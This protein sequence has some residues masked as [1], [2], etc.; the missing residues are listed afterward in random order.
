MTLNHLLLAGAVL[1]LVTGAGSA[2]ETQWKPA[3]DDFDSA[4]DRAVREG[5]EPLAGLIARAESATLDREPMW[6]VLGHYKRN[7]F[8]HVESD[9]DGDDF[10]LSA[11][12]RQDPRAELRATLAAFMDTR[13]LPPYGLSAQCRFAARLKWLRERLQIAPAVIPVEEC[14][15][16]DIFMEG[17]KGSRL[18]VVFPSAHPNN[19]SSMYGHTLLRVDADP[20][21]NTSSLLSYSVTYG[22]Q[23]ENV[24]AAA[25]IWKGLVG[26]LYGRFSILPYYL[27]LREYGQLEDR[28]VWEYALNVPPER[29]DM[30]LRHAWELAPTRFNYKFFTENCSYELLS[31]LDAGSPE[32]DLQG[33]FSAWVTP[34]DTLKAMR[35]AGLV[36]SVRYRPAYHAIIR[37]RRSSLTPQEQSIA[38]RIAREQGDPAALTANL[39]PARAA[40]TLDL[41]YDY[42]RYDRIREAHALDARLTPFERRVLLERS[43]LGITGDAVTPQVP[44]TAPDQGHGT[45]RMELGAASV[46]GHASAL[47]GYRGTYHDLLDPS[48]GYLANSQLE[49]VNL[50]LRIGESGDAV[51]LDR[52]TLLSIDSL[53]PRDTFFRNTSWALRTGFDSAFRDDGSRDVYYTVRGGAGYSYAPGEPERALFFGLVDATADVGGAFRDGGRL[54]AG[55]RAGFIWRP[56]PTLTL[57]LAAEWLTGIAGDRGDTGN[58]G[59][60]ASIPVGR[61]QSVRFSFAR[62]LFLG[63]YSNS[64]RLEWFYYR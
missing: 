8:G 61:N 52:L 5:I 36:E 33:R 45:L 60:S 2:E 43:R 32:L 10:F 29:I 58:A 27:K 21:R 30:V 39:E 48:P 56:L 24:P 49:F 41:A 17:M 38:Y 12:G 54:G 6:R 1:L 14:K 25:Q 47:L 7:L 34:V 63:D 18:T 26:G 4:A 42:L 40:G 23:I 50:Q 35:D 13:P 11:R 37:A 44:D 53:E 16:F 59:V 31:L 19:P 57:Q 22:A 20:A 62:D 15:T 46:D 55:A 64:G 9:V 51:R 28:D 3:G